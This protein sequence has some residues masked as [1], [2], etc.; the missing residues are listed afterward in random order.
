MVQYSLSNNYNLSKIV[1]STT[2][3]KIKGDNK[4]LLVL[5][6][7]QISMPRIITAL[8]VT[9]YPLALFPFSDKFP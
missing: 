7:Q 2:I 3:K 9:V 1:V 8:S 5:H 6:A 4:T